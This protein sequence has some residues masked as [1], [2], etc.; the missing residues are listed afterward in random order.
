MALN[1]TPNQIE[2][3]SYCKHI[4]NKWCNVKSDMLLY[5]CISALLDAE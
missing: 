3:R 4:G 2:V 1:M 5:N